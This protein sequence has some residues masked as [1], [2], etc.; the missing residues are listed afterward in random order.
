MVA[1]GCFCHCS[2]AQKLQ[3]ESPTQFGKV[4]FQKWR[5][6]L[7]NGG[8][9]IKVYIPIEG[10]SVNLDSVYFRGQVAKLKQDPNN[11]T[12]YVALLEWPGHTHKDLKMSTNPNDERDNALPIIPT[13]TPF[14]L[15]KDECVVSYSEDS[16]KLYYKISNLKEANPVHYPSAPNK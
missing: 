3:R 5:S 11:K 7:K 6:G 15:K 8:S 16:R 4:Y 12:S 9:G 10:Q 1:V 2:S 14:K 13:K